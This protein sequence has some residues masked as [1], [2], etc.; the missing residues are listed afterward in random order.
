MNSVS[1]NALGIK[2]LLWLSADVEQRALADVEDPV[3]IDVDW[4]LPG[5]LRLLACLA[6]PLHRAV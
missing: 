1:L 5:C 3:E 4:K 2:L 6:M